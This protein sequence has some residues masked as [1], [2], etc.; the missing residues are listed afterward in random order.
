MNMIKIHQVSS[1]ANAKV[2]FFCNRF[3]FFRKKVVGAA[4]AG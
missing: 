1:S 4:A 2:V 3:S